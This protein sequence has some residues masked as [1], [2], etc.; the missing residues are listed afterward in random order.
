VLICI[1][2]NSFTLMQITHCEQ[3]ALL[4]ACTIHAN[5]HLYWCDQIIFGEHDITNV[6]STLVII[7]TKKKYMAVVCN[8]DVERTY[9]RLYYVEKSFFYFG[10]FC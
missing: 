5:M 3:F 1:S 9:L 8:I 7:L 6:N 2:D 4:F 10:M